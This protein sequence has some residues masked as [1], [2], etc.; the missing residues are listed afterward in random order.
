MASTGSYRPPLAIVEPFHAL[1]DKS[2]Q[3][4]G[5]TLKYSDS[6]TRPSINSGPAPPSF[7]KRLDKY[8]KT[9]QLR[10]ID[11]FSAMDN[12]HNK[13]INLEEFVDGLHQ[14]NFGLTNEE[15][16]ELT[17]WMLNACDS[18]GV[19]F[20]EFSLALKL[21]VCHTS[22][23]SRTKGLSNGARKLLDISG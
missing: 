3:Q 11:V 21:R 18:D 10:P 12:N 4:N 5:T 16:S 13:K 14:I 23:T 20:K 9:N 22:P 2:R 7:F 15:L 1:K 17:D 19:S 8:I 6:T